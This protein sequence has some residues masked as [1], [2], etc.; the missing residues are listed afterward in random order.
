MASQT[1]YSDYSYS[2][3]IDFITSR[4][5]KLIWVFRRLRHV[6]DLDLLCTDYFALPQSVFSYCIG[7]WVGWY[8]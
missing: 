3:R 6:T 1:D 4:V 8:L 2:T 5:R 7:T